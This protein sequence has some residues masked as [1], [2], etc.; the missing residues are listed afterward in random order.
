MNLGQ[1][2]ISV[3]FDGVLAFR[4]CTAVS[5]FCVHLNVVCFHHHS[6]VCTETVLSAISNHLHCARLHGTCSKE[7]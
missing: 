7:F 6:D 2:D 3:Q 4:D 5:I 1:L